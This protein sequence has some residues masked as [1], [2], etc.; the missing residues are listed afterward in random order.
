MTG[1]LIRWFIL[2]LSIIAAAYTVE[3]IAVSGFFAAL[4]AAAVLG[5]L[6]AVLRPI[7]IVLTLPINI[8]SLGLFTFLINALLLKMVS[9]VISGFDIHGFWPAVLGALMISIV[10]WIL[11][12]LIGER[13][14]VEVI[15]LRKRGDRWE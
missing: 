10:S 11:N 1:I 6:N 3:G 13:G 14:Q 15:D 9:G 2:T 7:L 4:F 5:I 12:A 8:L